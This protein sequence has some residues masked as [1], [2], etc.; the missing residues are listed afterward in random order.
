MNVQVNGPFGRVSRLVIDTDGGVDDLVAIDVAKRL[1][2]GELTVTT[3]GGNVS[4]AQAAQTVAFAN[5][6]VASVGQNPP[7]WTPEHRHGVDGMH[8]M[9]DGQKRS[10]DPTPA[11]D[12][13]AEVMTDK[14][15][16]IACIGP[17]TNIASA[18]DKVER[19][20]G[21]V[22]ATIYALG[23]LSGAPRGLRDTNVYADRS[24]AKMSSRLVKWVSMKEAALMTKTSVADVKDTPS[25]KWVYPFAERTSVTWGWDG[26]FPL[27]DVAVVCA[28]LG[29][30]KRARNEIC[31]VF[32]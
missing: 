31:N 14:G 2:D 1:Y 22:R 19:S 12:R 9:W 13:L 8:G 17:L 23:G 28:A 11:V 32:A 25:W 4:A 27:Y 3:V 20:C 18:I 21:V 6:E 29:A 24:A 5:N 30:R 7:G 16:A 26:H 15:G 10:I